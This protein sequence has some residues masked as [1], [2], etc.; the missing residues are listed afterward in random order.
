MFHRDDQ[1]FD[2]ILLIDNKISD[3]EYVKQKIK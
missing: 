2:K 1:F 3:E